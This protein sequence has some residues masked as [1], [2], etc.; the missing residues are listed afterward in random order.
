M[1][2]NNGN[3]T[4]EEVKKRKIKDVISNKKNKLKPSSV[5]KT[6]RIPVKTAIPNKTE[7][8]KI[9]ASKKVDP[10]GQAEHQLLKLKKSDFKITQFHLGE[11]GHYINDDPYVKDITANRCKNYDD[12]YKPAFFMSCRDTKKILDHHPGPAI[13]IMNNNPENLVSQLESVKKRDNIYFMST[14]A[15]MSS[16]LDRLN[17]KYVEFPWELEARDDWS[18]VTKGNSIYVYGAG[19]NTNMYGWHTIKRIVETHFPHLNIICTSHKKSVPNMPP[20]QY[21]TSQEL[22]EIYKKCFLS[23]RLTRFDGLS[24]TVQDL[25]AKGIKTIWNGGTPSALPYE[26]EQD[27]IDHIRNEEKLIG[28]RNIKLSNSVKNFLNMDRK[29]YDYIFDLNTYMNNSSEISHR[30]CTPIL[31]KNPYNIPAMLF[32]DLVGNRFNMNATSVWKDNNGKRFW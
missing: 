6:K 24:G 10:I 20:F 27:I 18:A 3:K 8:W 5:K 4:Y 14:S 23:I 31:F 21:Y 29:D 32:H 7:E 13:I 12:P 2:K 16:Y 9:I 1:K 19:P 22:E 25:G 11:W 17:L 26:S 15:I 30:N 28:T